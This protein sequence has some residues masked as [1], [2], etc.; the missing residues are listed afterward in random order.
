MY[1]LQQKQCTTALN[2]KVEFFF[3]VNLFEIL[4]AS[5]CDFYNYIYKV[6]KPAADGNP[7]L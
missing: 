4:H 1:S 5:T 6:K 7:D 2:K 3:Q